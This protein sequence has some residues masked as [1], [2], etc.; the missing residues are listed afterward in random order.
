LVIKIAAF[1]AIMLLLILSGST[2]G[3][4]STGRRNEEFLPL[5]MTAMVA[6]LFA[7]GL[8][9]CLE[10]GLVLLC[11]MFCCFFVLT[12]KRCITKGKAV[13]KQIFTPASI[14][15]VFT[16]AALIF[17][18]YGRCVY[19]I[20]EMTHWADS[21]K[22]MF[23]YN[24]LPDA[25][26]LKATFPSYPPGMA[27]MQYLF[28]KLYAALVSSGEFTE[29]VL[30]LAYQSFMLSFFFPFLK[31]LDVKKPVMSLLSFALV[32][33]LPLMMDHSDAFSSL[34]IDPFMAMV[35]ACGL[36]M[37]FSE[38]CKNKWYN[39]YIFSCCF[40]LVVVKP[41]GLMLGAFL[42]ACYVAELLIRGGSRREKLLRTTAVSAVVALPVVLWSVHKAFSGV[43]Q[44]FSSKEAEFDFALLLRLVCHKE[45]E[46]W[47]Q[48]VHDEYY[49][50]IF[51]DS[52]R[53]KGFMCPYWLIL[54]FSAVALYV[55][56]R[57]M[58]RRSP[59][60]AAARKIVFPSVVIISVI[61]YVSLCYMYIFMF[62]WWEAIVLAQLSRYIG[63]VL[64]AVYAAAM[65]VFV[66]F[67]LEGNS[68]RAVCAAFV[69]FMV[70]GPFGRALEIVKRTNL[71]QSDEH[72]SE[73]KAL[74]QELDEL[75]N[76]EN[77]NLFLVNQGSRGVEFYGFR[78]TIRPHST[79]D[80]GS[81]FL[82]ASPGMDG[83]FEDRFI[84]AKDWQKDLVEN[85]DYVFIYG[86]D[87][88]FIENYQELFA[89]G[90]EPEE[91]W[92]YGISDEGLLIKECRIENEL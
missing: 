33:M 86:V 42:A 92:L 82:G 71:G 85:Y 61:Y 4:V 32:M 8:A 87:Q 76:G 74:A 48:I 75:S 47:Q 26:T 45:G 15:F 41:A 9:G 91:M 14:L 23:F 55:V 59:E 67:V 46:S 5:S 80:Y 22:A 79:V 29:W 81:W 68:K 57:L 36:A 66:R 25:A 10:L 35:F 52:V 60:L 40:M 51:T 64:W 24:T 77:L 58:S 39:A 17:I 1:S 62:G 88:Y 27:L 78:Y 69:V 37:V 13:L 65:L 3:A 38:E 2:L 6:V 44:S 73:F 7:F 18:N 56:L 31:R 83:E 49:L 28:T 19:R 20:D 12:I 50:R 90:S 72:Y 11:L 70:F 89:E 53:I 43:T 54:L 34:Y 30:Y 63:I 21:A 84:E 16:F